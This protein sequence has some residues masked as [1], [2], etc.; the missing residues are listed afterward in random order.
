MNADREVGENIRQA[1]RVRGVSQEELG[2]RVG[3]SKQM[4][5][6]YETGESSISAVRLREVCDALNFTP[7]A[8]LRRAISDAPKLIE[9]TEQV[10]LVTAYMA[11]TKKR[12]Q[13]VRGLMRELRRD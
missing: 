11:L 13:I 1:R 6:K 5:Q 2:A 8:L 7:D 4:I 12:R 10:K 3:V 9:G